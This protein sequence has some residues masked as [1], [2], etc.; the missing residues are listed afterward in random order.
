MWTLTGGTSYVRR[1]YSKDC[2]ILSLVSYARRQPVLGPHWETEQGSG[3]REV[4]QH[5]TLLLVKTG[6]WDYFAGQPATT[7]GMNFQ[8]FVE[9][10]LIVPM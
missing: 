7:I 3:R 4:I 2:M 8:C 10:L 6:S 9:F 1:S 5:A